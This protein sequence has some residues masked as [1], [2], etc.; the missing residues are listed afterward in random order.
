MVILSL[1]LWSLT[2]PKIFNSCVDICFC[3]RK[4]KW[5][6]LYIRLCVHLKWKIENWIYF[7]FLVLT[8]FLLYVTCLIK[9]KMVVLLTKQKSRLTLRWM[10]RHFKQYQAVMSAYENQCSMYVAVPISGPS[11]PAG[12]LEQL[13]AGDMLHRCPLKLS[14]DQ[15]EAPSF[16]HLVIY[17]CVKCVSET[18]QGTGSVWSDYVSFGSGGGWLL[19]S[20]VHGPRAGCG[21]WHSIS[22]RMRVCVRV[23][24]T[25][26]SISCSS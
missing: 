2:D 19:W 6:L 14:Q 26:F 24:V 23:A 22:I 25:C 4:L 21:E 1:S 3:Y 20:A 8:R 10:L 18:F 15:C 17:L 13:P 12:A 7:N 9:N 5:N 11:S 16:P